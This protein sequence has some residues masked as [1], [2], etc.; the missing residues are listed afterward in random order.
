MNCCILVYALAVMTGIWSP[1]HAQFKHAPC[2]TSLS[3]PHFKSDSTFSES[4]NILIQKKVLL[5]LKQSESQFEIRVY[6]APYGGHGPVTVIKC[7]D[8]LLKIHKYQYFFSS[9]NGN[10]NVA[11][12]YVNLGPI[13]MGSQRNLY[14]NTSIVNA[15]ANETTTAFL[16][17]LIDNHLFDLPVQAEIETMIQKKHPMLNLKGEN[18]IHLQIKIGNSYK[19]MKYSLSYDATALDIP[20]YKSLMNIY[21][22]LNK[23]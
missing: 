23:F 14:L 16:Q 20:A 5:P 1:V 8:S 12:G 2:A 17:V 22:V 21:N 7:E 13:E 9:K 11:E 6:S 4:D 19:S 15:D 3:L 10:K 18:L